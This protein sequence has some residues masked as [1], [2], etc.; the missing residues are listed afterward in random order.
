MDVRILMAHAVTVFDVVVI[1][2]TTPNTRNYC[3]L[4]RPSIDRCCE[5]EH[6]YLGAFVCVPLCVRVNLRDI[7]LWHR[8][9]CVCVYSVS[10]L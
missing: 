8:L 3:S 10:V 9:L 6:T 5:D 4:H 2:A 7:A 1:D